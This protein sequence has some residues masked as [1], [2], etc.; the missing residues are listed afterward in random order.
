MKKEI[1]EN[2][3]KEEW[4]G[5]KIVSEMLDNPDENDIYPTS[6]CY[7]KLYEFV[8]KQKDKAKEETKREIMLVVN[9]MEKEPADMAEDICKECDFDFTS[10]MCAKVGSYN[11]AL[12]DILKAIK[13]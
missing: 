12:S 6:K 7:Q 2:Y 10:V 3:E 4:G 9:K 8:C 1:K 5:W 11:K 13:V